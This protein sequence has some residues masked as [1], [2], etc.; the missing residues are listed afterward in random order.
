M[1]PRA[2]FKGYL[3]LSLVSCAVALFPAT[4]RAERISFHILN[5]ST[6]NRVRN[7]RVDA[8]TG[9]VVESEDRLDAVMSNVFRR[10]GRPVVSGLAIV[11]DGLALE[12][13]E[14]VPA[15]GADVF[16][17][18]PAVIHARFTGKPGKKLVVKGTAAD[19]KAWRA[20][21][22]LR[23]LLLTDGLTAPREPVPPGHINATPRPR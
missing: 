16:P 3:K 19:G 18:V 21:V 14:T 17:G 20:E 7:Q 11:P 12:A 9:D 15:Q 13:G 5:R 2:N 8:E 1:A 22:E 4:S 6:G 23:G 10:I